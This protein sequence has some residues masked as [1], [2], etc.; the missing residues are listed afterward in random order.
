M[1]PSLRLEDA[2]ILLGPPRA[3]VVNEI[4]LIGLLA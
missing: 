3:V 1:E 2:V 4:A